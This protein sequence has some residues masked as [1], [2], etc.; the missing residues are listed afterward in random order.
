MLTSQ[1]VKG[2]SINDDRLFMVGEN[3][4]T[5]EDGARGGRA[6]ERGVVQFDFEMT[7]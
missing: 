6:G 1:I 2:I 7:E 4:R 3:M 5:D